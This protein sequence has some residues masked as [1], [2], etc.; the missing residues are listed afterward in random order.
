M[1]FNFNIADM[2]NFMFSCYIFIP[3]SNPYLQLE[4][5][6][7]V[8]AQKSLQYLTPETEYL[9]SKQFRHTFI[10]WNLFSLTC[11]SK[12]NLSINLLNVSCILFHFVFFGDTL[13]SCLG[14]CHYNL[15]FILDHPIICKTF[16]YM[17]QLDNTGCSHF[18]YLKI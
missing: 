3:S 18:W 12:Q 9:L 4:V 5:N 17:N 6:H 1:L 13:T 16:K 10:N 15:S 8:F 14:S 2:C 11:S 7:L